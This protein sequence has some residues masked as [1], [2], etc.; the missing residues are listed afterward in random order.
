MRLRSPELEHGRCWF[1]YLHRP[2]GVKRCDSR[3]WRCW[4]VA[5]G[6]SRGGCPPTPHVRQPRFATSRLRGAVR[7]R[8]SRRVSVMPGG[9]AK[10]RS[11]QHADG[12]TTLPEGRFALRGSRYV[13][14]A[15]NGRA[16]R[17]CG[18]SQIG[19]SIR[20]VF[21]PLGPGKHLSGNSRTTGKNS[22]NVFGNF[23]GGCLTGCPECAAVRAAVSQADRRCVPNRHSNRL[24]PWDESPE[25]PAWSGRDEC[26]AAQEHR[27]FRVSRAIVAFAP[28]Q[29]PCAS[30]GNPALRVLALAVMP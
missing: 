9:A 28:W 8:A 17:T 3:P 21:L 18:S 19:D 4:G 22:A 7:R 1:G 6:G 14:A 5:T 29:T 16:I 12:S 2:P 20:L 24:S 11:R 27:E 25:R 26:G 10:Q 30:S 23:S 15:G 13:V